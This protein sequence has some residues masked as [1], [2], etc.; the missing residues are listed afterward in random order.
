MKKRNILTI[1]ILSMI[2]FVPIFSF[3]DFVSADDTTFYMENLIIRQNR[4]ETSF[5]YDFVGSYHIIN[6][7]ISTGEDPVYYTYYYFTVT[8]NSVQY[9]MTDSLINPNAEEN[10]TYCVGN[11]HSSFISSM[12]PTPSSFNETVHTMIKFRSDYLIHS[13]NHD[14]GYESKISFFNE[15]EEVIYTLNSSQV[16]GYSYVTYSLQPIITLNAEFFNTQNTRIEY[17]TDGT[18]WY[19]TTYGS[20]TIDNYHYKCRLYNAENNELIYQ[21]LS[22]VNFTRV[23]EISIDCI[24]LVNNADEPVI[25]YISNRTT[26]YNNVTYYNTPDLV[27]MFSGT[28]NSSDYSCLDYDDFNAL[29]LSPTG[30][31]VGYYRNDTA[32]YYPTYDY[33]FNGTS[34]NNFVNMQSIDSSYY[35]MYS[36]AENSS[37][38]DYV[39]NYTTSGFVPENVSIINGT[40]TSSVSSMAT[41]NGISYR[42]YSNRTEGPSDVYWQYDIYIDINISSLFNSGDVIDDSDFETFYIKWCYIFTIYG[43]ASVLNFSLYDWDVSTWDLMHSE[44]GGISYPDGLTNTTWNADH[45]N[46]STHVIRYRANFAQEKHGVDP[47][48]YPDLL[49]LDI[50]Q[51]LVKFHYEDHNQPTYNW[52]INL[53]GFIE[54]DFSDLYINGNI[55]SRTQFVDSL[56]TWNWATNVSN[57]VSFYAYNWDT[58]TWD[59]IINSSQTSFITNTS[60]IFDDT[61]YIH[62]SSYYADFRIEINRTASNS[63]LYDCDIKWQC[64][65]ASLWLNY[66]NQLEEYKYYNI[67]AQIKWDYYSA[68]ITDYEYDW[69]IHTNMSYQYHTNVTVD[70]VNIAFRFS[71]TSSD[72]FHE[73][74]Y[75]TTTLITN[76]TMDR[77]YINNGI[78]FLMDIN[79]SLLWYDD[80]DFYLELANASVFFGN[81]SDQIYLYT[82]NIDYLSYPYSEASYALESENPFGNGTYLDPYVYYSYQVTDMYGNYLVNR[83]I[84]NTFYSNI[85]LIYTP[86]YTRECLVSYSDQQGNYLNWF[87]YKTKINGT[88]IY[89]PIFYREIGTDINVSVYDRFDNYITSTVWTVE[90]EENWISLTITLYSLK[91]FNQQDSYAYINLTST[92]SISYWSEWVAPDE[93]V[94]YKLIAGNYRLN[95]TK[96]EETTITS[97]YNYTLI[98][99]DIL[100]INSQYTLLLLSKIQQMSVFSELVNW[101]DIYDNL[102]QI[103]LYDFVNSYAEQ[104][105]KVYLRYLGSIDSIIVG[106]GDTI[107]QIFPNTELDEIDF[108]VKNIET[109]EFLTDWTPLPS[110]KTVDIGFYEADI[111]ATPSDLQVSNITIW[112]M[113]ILSLIVIA[114]FAYM[115]IRAENKNSPEKSMRKTLNI[116]NEELKENAKKKGGRGRYIKFN[117]D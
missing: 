90:R 77:K 59:F 55:T 104:N 2:I 84:M 73:E 68:I 80:Y 66:S 3:I 47:D 103:A 16:S 52:T 117:L 109:D 64:D 74:I 58:V 57:N 4:G 9:N 94:E 86:P 70:S 106:A 115:W 25:F 105:V 89:E 50:D 43:G 32:T 69:V 46:N 48:D 76:S 65:L 95:V 91:I 116:T 24:R 13:D 23:R 37:V 112:I 40:S 30:T 44:T 88:I 7:S 99:D 29:L 17:T 11:E 12:S 102:T 54:F 8:N 42:L 22:F 87:A 72:T 31:A 15:S 38:I 51:I 62:S 92:I 101:T 111:P 96:Y 93:I 49:A 97:A 100:L 114:F 5:R 33:M 53:D 61:K 1:V 6:S 83:T 20:F 18:S 35:M 41:K 67:S 79:V 19:E 98:G 45:I 14:L 82:P 75:T 10:Y 108:R 26:S 27:S 110:N 78:R 81:Q 28:K 113:G 34:N 39:W 71:N 107:S 21:D 36:N 60:N 63:T 56:L 85:T